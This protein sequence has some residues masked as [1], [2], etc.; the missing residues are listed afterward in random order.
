MAFWFKRGLTV[1]QILSERGRLPGQWMEPLEKRQLLAAPVVD[2]VQSSFLVNNYVQVP[3][4]KSLILPLTAS[5]ADSDKLTYTVTSSNPNITVDLHKKNPYLKLSV[6]Y[7]KM[8]DNVL[9][10]Q[11]GE[12]V[13]QLLKDV[14]P[15]TVNI[16][17]SLVEAGYYNGLTFHRVVPGF[18]V[19]GGRKS[20]YEN[21]P[22]EFDD[23][24]DPKAIYSGRGQLAMAKGGDDTNG[25]QFFITTTSLETAIDV[26]KVRNLDFNHTIFGQV[27]R[28]WEH[29]TGLQSVA[30]KI[31]TE[32]PVTPPTITKAELVKDWT[33]AVVTITA[34]AGESG[35]I[36]VKVD[37]GNGGT[38]TK[39]FNVKAV[40]DPDK[41]NTRPYFTPLKDIYAPSGKVINIRLKPYDLEKDAYDYSGS[42]GGGAQVL[43]D[44]TDKTNLKFYAFRG[45]VGP[46]TMSLY[47]KPQTSTEQPSGTGQGNVDWDTFV[48]AVGD[49]PP[50][51]LTGK[52]ITPVSG[53]A[54]DTNHPFTVATFKDTDLKG[55]VADWSATINWGDGTTPT[56]ATIVKNSNGT[57]SIRGTHKFPGEGWYRVAA[58]LTSK[59]GGATHE[60]VTVAKVSDAPLTPTAVKLYGKTDTAF[61]NVLVGKF[62]DADPNGLAADF[63]VKIDWGD[64]TALADATPVKNGDFFEVKGT[65][66]YTAAGTYTVTTHVTDKGGSAT[67]VVSTLYVARS[68][69]TFDVGALTQTGINEA[70]AGNFT[71]TGKKLIDADTESEHSYRLWVDYG[72]GDGFESV[73]LAPDDSFDLGHTYNDSGTYTVNLFVKDDATHTHSN[74][75]ITVTVDGVGPKVETLT[76][77]INGVPGQLRTFKFTASDVSPVDT[78][79]GYTYRVR[80]GDAG[81]DQTTATLATG[82]STLTHTYTAPGT[83]TVTVWARDKD[84][85]ESEAG[86][87]KTLTVTIVAVQLQDDPKDAA[88]HILAIG[89]TNGADTIAITAGDPG[90]I[91]VKIGNP[92]AVPYDAP[93]RIQVF[94]LDGADTISVAD[95]ITIGAEISGGGGIDT[96]TGGGGDDTLM[97]DNDGDSLVGGGGNDILLGGAGN[98]TMLGGLGR[99]MLIG[100]YGNDSL[101]GGEGEDI[102]IEGTTKHDAKRQIFATILQE[103]VR[104]DVTYATRVAR[105]GGASGGLNGKFRFNTN[106][107]FQDGAADT[108]LGAQGNDLFLANSTDSSPW[109]QTDKLNDRNDG[110]TLVE[111]GT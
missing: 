111:L 23:E 68:T 75:T 42:V 107:V 65:H 14:A 78:D 90:K 8:V 1:D 67:D 7:Q 31:N 109:V 62:K 29:V 2:S 52:P 39:T 19:Q 41:Y 80:W 9:Q 16:I 99:D 70:T 108:L 20:L 4:G 106:T 64:D 94:G 36:T 103:W 22:F 93:N 57:F 25:T 40:N 66:T 100:G 105:L 37:D 76:G 58:E 49:L 55:K 53:K 92:D 61:A 97:G 73:T 5:D 84:S 6:S 17:S 51:A 91:N 43:F 56:D 38:N 59:P 69:L 110:E 85:K 28:G 26:D 77:D 95:T 74:E 89:G 79:K 86:K 102:L 96:L 46:V 15:N 34:P 63:T 11:T 33:D 83:Y 32:E 88:K 13:M 21:S 10:T 30:L 82:T 12:I 71:R 60:I 44:P 45:F 24:F 3:S 104:N 87:E 48:V 18:V 81:G 98:D 35:T 54:E 50:T 47:V 101:N 27:V 72:D